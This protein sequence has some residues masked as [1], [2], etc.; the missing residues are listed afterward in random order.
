MIQVLVNAEAAAVPEPVFP[1]PPCPDTALA[2]NATPE[3]E[4]AATAFGAL[5]FP[6]P[7][8]ARVP[9]LDA[10]LPCPTFPACRGRSGI[11]LPWVEPAA[12]ATF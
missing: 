12:P 7:D 9:L 6:A 8:T 5:T 1:E 4:L 2:D 11:E 10:G 3:L